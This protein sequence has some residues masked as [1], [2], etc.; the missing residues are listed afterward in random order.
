MH[1]SST[2]H[3]EGVEVGDHGLHVGL[4]IPRSESHGIGPCRR[5]VHSRL[6]GH[7]GPEDE[8]MTTTATAAAIRSS[9]SSSLQLL[10]PLLPIRAGL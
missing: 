6:L 10:R 2:A 3:R 1:P 5:D 4:R 9:S 7:E 8:T